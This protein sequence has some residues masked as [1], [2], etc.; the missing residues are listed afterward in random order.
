LD[1]ICLSIVEL[2]DLD[3]FDFLLFDVFK[4][5]MLSFD[6]DLSNKIFF[7][8]EDAVFLYTTDSALLRIYFL[9]FS[10]LNFDGV[11]TESKLLFNSFE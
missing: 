6:L 7:A 1:F 8:F 11:F 10:E 2:E 4:L 3:L 9:T 5:S